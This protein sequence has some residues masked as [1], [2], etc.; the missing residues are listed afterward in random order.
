MSSARCGELG[1]FTFRFEVVPGQV[2][3]QS[4]KELPPAC[5]LDAALEVLW[6]DAAFHHRPKLRIC[7]ALLP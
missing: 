1:A 4:L 3:A 7:P 6:I 5:P 2:V